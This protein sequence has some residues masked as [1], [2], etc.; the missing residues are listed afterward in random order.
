MLHRAL[1]LCGS[2]NNFRVIKLRRMRWL[3]HV[4]C[5]GKMRNAH[6]VLI[7]NLEGRSP[8]GNLKSRCEDN[9]RMDLREIVFGSVDWIHLAQDVGQWRVVVNTVMNI[10]FP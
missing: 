5:V 6:T 7:G 10:R 1:G 3:G 9:I 2:P 8:L 4:A